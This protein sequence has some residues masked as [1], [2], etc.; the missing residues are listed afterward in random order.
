MRS[1]LHSQT[2]KQLTRVA[3]AK[4]DP[5]ANLLPF[6]SRNRHQ[7]FENVAKR[8]ASLIKFAGLGVMPTKSSG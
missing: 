4:V 3:P 1:G 6:P 5:S 8:L 7:L 2:D